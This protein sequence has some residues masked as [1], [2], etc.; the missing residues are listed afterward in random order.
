MSGENWMI[1][2]RCHWPRPSH[3]MAA[4]AA[5][6][7]AASPS[8]AAAGSCA[9]T[10]DPTATRAL[11]ADLAAD[12]PGVNT[13]IN[14]LRSIYD[15]GYATI[16]K[17][18]LLEL[19]V[20]HIR[21]NPGGDTDKMTK[22]RFTELA[23]SGIKLL[24]A[25]AN[26]A[27]YDIDYVKA[28]NVGGLQVVE[29]VEPPNERDNAWGANMP[30]QMRS[31][32]LALYPRYHGDPATSNVIVLGPSFANTR[33]SA[34]KL[35]AVFPNAASYMDIGNAHSYSGRDPEG[36]YGGGWSIYLA[37]A[38][39][40][41]RM[42]STKPVWAS[43][44]G[45]KLMHSSSGHPAVTQRAAAKYLPRQFLS[46]LLRGAPRLYVYQLLKHNNE[47]FALLNGDGSA[48][49]PFIAMKNYIATFSDP[50]ATFAPGTLRFSL[51]G[52]LTNLQQALFQKRDGRFLLAVWQGVPSS[53]APAT[54][55]G[56][57]DIEPARRALTL[58]LGLPITRATIYEPSFATA[59][60]RSYANAAG[61]GVVPLS[62]ADH[63]Q[64]IELVPPAAR[65]RA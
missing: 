32:M 5:A 63:L 22:G 4:I 7:L 53:T 19:G 14:Y 38:I 27:D 43:E 15:T 11:M 60:V 31:Y 23:R 6:W 20:R 42:G 50:G 8:A 12:V 16:V 3:A 39:G 61:L 33:D 54:D 44:N 52:D 18:R 35:Q 28:L 13:H 26:T 10:S 1:D 41:Q 34:Q 25:T 40:R 2:R 57:A 21:D 55:S 46:H 65:N 30:A 29:A 24:M 17:P 62:V 48:R 59:P 47:D 58:T 56:I 64:V 9:A 37:D 45:Y 36:R 51:G 49:L